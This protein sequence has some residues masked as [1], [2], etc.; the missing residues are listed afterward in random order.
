[1]ATPKPAPAPAQKGPP[2]A[3]I[4]GGAGVLVLALAA[5]AYFVLHKPA[6]ATVTPPVTP[7]AVVTTPQKPTPV[8][9]PAP[10]QLT[11]AQIQS[12]VTSTLGALPCTL[13]AASMP[14]GGG[15]VTVGGLAGAG[16]PQAALT[17]RRFPE[18]PYPG[19]RRPVLRPDEHGAAVPAAVL[20]R[21][22]HPGADRRRPAAA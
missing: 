8:T 4:G 21:R 13:L 9:P 17:R 10:V 1:M 18:Q 3:L 19:G 22:D 12:A 6:P 15:A 20:L 5:G 11:A 2:V 16:A 7:Q 14:A